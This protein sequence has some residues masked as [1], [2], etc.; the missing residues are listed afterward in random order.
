MSSESSLPTSLAVALRIEEGITPITSFALLTVEAEGVVDALATLARHLVTVADGV[1]VDVAVALALL[2]FLLI[3]G[4]SKE[5]VAALIT[6]S[7]RVSGGAF[8]AKDIAVRVKDA[9]AILGTG[10]RLAVF[11]RSGQRVSVEATRATLACVTGR[12]V[13]ADTRA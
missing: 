6:S 11:R 12:V 1:G 9:G 5:S 13:L 4:V 7:A 10:T 3:F 2:A 8:R